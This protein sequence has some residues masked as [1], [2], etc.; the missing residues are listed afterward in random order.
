MQHYKCLKQKALRAL[1]ILA[2]FFS[3]FI[4]LFHTEACATTVFQQRA[5][6]FMQDN[7]YDSAAVYF[8][9]YYESLLADSLD[10]LARTAFRTGRSLARSGEYDEAILWFRLSAS[11]FREL[12]N[13]DNYWIAMGNVSSIYQDLGKYKDAIAL[14]EETFYFF[15]QENDT[16]EMGK[17]LNNLALTYYR[18]QQTDKAIEIYLRSIEL[19]GN[20]Y[21]DVTSKAYNQLGNIWAM[22]LHDERKALSYYLKSLEMKKGFDDP[23]SL[24]VAYNNVGISYKNLQMPDSALVNYH[25]A[26]DYAE[27][28]GRADRISDPLINLGKIYSQEGEPEKALRYLSRAEAMSDK[29]TFRQKIIVWNTMGDLLLEREDYNRALMFY[30][31]VE[32][33]ALSENIYDEW[34]DVLPGKAMAFAGLRDFERA[35]QIQRQFQHASDSLSINENRQVVADLMV[36]YETAEKELALLETEKLVREK[37]LKL[38][39]RTL[40]ILSALGLVMLVSGLA[41]TV[42]RQKK[43]VEKQALL[44]LNLAEQKSINKLQE[45][46]LNISRELHDNIGSQLTFVN[47][48]LEQFLYAET[49]PSQSQLKLL[50]ENLTQSMRELRKTVWLISKTSATIDEI[51]LKLR[52]IL[53]P[54]QQNG[55]RIDVIASGATDLALNE[56]QTTHVFRIIQEATNNAIKHASCS[57]IVVRL[58]AEQKGLVSISVEDDGS[59]FDENVVQKSHGLKNMQYRAEQ[60]KGVFQIE[61]RPGRGTVISFRFPI[62]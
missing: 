6:S 49:P 7:K 56:L 29:L 22:D 12:G 53:K 2:L 32:N 45:D 19:L 60:I 3:P 13:M 30:S 51:S 58:K 8:K 31:R 36:K 41:F 10:P 48:G 5:M 27:K 15:Q 44:Q 55:H 33:L 23:G 57:K 25:L 26:L 62:A 50:K 37:E 16:L 17:T 21:P 38:K 47:A 24:S 11:H 46:R 14:A 39:N 61:S 52:D 4:Y 20:D 35:F 40:W 59:G 18:N 28:S 43:A 54:V 9:M 42:Y 34:V 1:V